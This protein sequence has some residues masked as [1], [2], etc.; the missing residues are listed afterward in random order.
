MIYNNWGESFFIHG[1][2]LLIPSIWNH[3]SSFWRMPLL[4]AIA[5]IS[6][7]YALKKR[8]AGQYAKERINRL[9]VPLIFGMLLIVPI[10]PY[11]AGLF[12]NG[13]AN[14]FD[15]FTKVTDLYGYDSSFT[16]GH[17]WFLLFLFVISMIS[18]PFMIWYKRKGQ[19]TLGGKAPLILIILLGLLPCIV[20]SDI[21]E[22]LEI[23]RKSL[24]EYMAYF[25]L[26]FFFLTNDD[27][28]K[29]LDKYRF[30]L[31]GLFVLDAVCVTYLLDG[32]FYEMA[33]W[34]AIV[35]ALGMSRHYLDFRGK[36][37]TYLAKSSFGVYMFH[38]SWIVITA[39]FFFFLTSNP[40]LQIPL[41]FLSTIILTYSTYEI[42]RRIPLCRWMFGLS[43]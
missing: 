5:G 22:P 28:L 29:K 16:P 14:Y 12:F 19:G 3:I 42:C 15:Y 10:Q 1:E 6:S 24:L 26:G 40:N 7:H 25:L 2:A 30:L 18:L 41:I 38:Q 39:F 43:K 33:S 11:L 8:N 17:L 32:E 20:Q 4:A 37:T 36:I 9:F 23:G 13:H 27:L 34:L 21:F 31:L 35:A